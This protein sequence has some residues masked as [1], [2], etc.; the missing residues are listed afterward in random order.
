VYVGVALGVIISVGWM[1]L[2]MRWWMRNTFASTPKGVLR[3]LTRTGSVHLK[4]VKGIE[5]VWNPAKPLG[6]DN[7]VFGP[8][9]A[10]YSLD[11]S[12]T[13]HLEFRDGSGTMLRYSGP[14]PDALIHPTQDALRARSLLRY[15]LVGYVALMV[16]GFV[17]GYAAAGGS[18]LHRLVAGAVGL[19]I[20]MALVWFVTLLLRVG[21]SVR[22]L[23]RGK[24]ESS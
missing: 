12:G 20:V 24:N 15:V 1:V 3:H 19:F 13:V 2:F 8:G 17:V 18:T 14:I 16:V 22:S 5:G 23:V 10:T 21:Q 11:D 9:E 6:P 4:H 7:Q